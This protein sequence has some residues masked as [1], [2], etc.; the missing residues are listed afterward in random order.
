MKSHPNQCIN[1]FQVWLDSSLLRA[2]SSFLLLCLTYSL[3]RYFVTIGPF[4]HAAM[5]E[6]VFFLL[7]D[8][9]A[10]EHGGFSVISSHSL[11]KI[12]IECD[13]EM[14]LCL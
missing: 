4:E 12:Q 1:L 6:I 11:S 9:E 10:V 5:S 13:S 2:S 7:L 8:H 14:G 3:K